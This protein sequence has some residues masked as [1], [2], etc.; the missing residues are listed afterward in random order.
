MPLDKFDSDE[1]EIHS[2][3]E[4]IALSQENNMLAHTPKYISG[5][6]TW[7]RCKVLSYDHAA[8]RYHVA[9]CDAF[10]NLTGGT[11]DVKRLSLRFDIEEKTMFDVRKES[12]RERREKTKAAVSLCTVWPCPALNFPVEDRSGTS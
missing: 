1:Y 8:E 6:W 5:E 11:K 7:V 2:P 3:D 4:W 9:F 12:A 10:G